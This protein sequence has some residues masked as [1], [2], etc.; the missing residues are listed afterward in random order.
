VITP[1][2]LGLHGTLTHLTEKEVVNIFKAIVKSREIKQYITQYNMLNYAEITNNEE[3]IEFLL[4]RG[5]ATNISRIATK[6]ALEKEGV[7]RDVKIDNTDIKGTIKSFLGKGKKK[8]K[9]KKI[10][11]VK[12]NKTYRKI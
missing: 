12:K 2:I 9:S 10:K 3:F 8:S 1:D 5:L 6:I 7:D 11:N 4:R